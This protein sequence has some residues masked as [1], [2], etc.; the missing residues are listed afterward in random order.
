MAINESMVRRIVGLLVERGTN[1]RIA[2]FGYPDIT[3]PIEQ[4]H[5][6]AGVT[7]G[8]KTRADSEAICKRHAKSFRPI[9]DVAS[10]FALY[11]AML[12]VYDMVQERGCEILCDLNHYDNCPKTE[13][14]DIVIDPGT[15]EHCFNIGQAALNI[16]ACVAEG[17]HILHANPFMAG[18]HGFYSL[19]PTWYAD[20]YEQ[21]GFELLS[22][23]MKASA[24]NYVPMTDTGRFCPTV[25]FNLFAVA[26][27]IKV[28]PLK[29]PVQTKYKQ[30]LEKHGEAA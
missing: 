29:W 23:E 21:N 14:Y 10:F 30:S 2:S 8:I 11:G 12:D 25:E 28:Q 4:L 5:A 22:C 18:N 3:M 13:E 9:A 24:M 7:N 27:R 17:G 26:K 15:L 20:F 1:Q 19:N 6:L 16:A